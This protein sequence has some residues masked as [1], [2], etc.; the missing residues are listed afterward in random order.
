MSVGRGLVDVEQWQSLWVLNWSCTCNRE[1]IYCQAIFNLLLQL[2]CHCRNSRELYQ[3]RI[4]RHG[5]TVRQVIFML[6]LC[7][8]TS[9]FR[10][11][12]F[13]S[14]LFI[15]RFSKNTSFF[16]SAETCLYISRCRSFIP[17]SFSVERDW[18][19]FLSRH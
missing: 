13:N 6:S 11:S 19:L 9:N 3:R 1:D 17:E 15:R 4:V 18:L 5:S 7:I 12:N 10:N 8:K 16:F 14:C 2:I